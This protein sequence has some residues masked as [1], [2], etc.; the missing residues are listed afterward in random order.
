MSRFC[1]SGLNA[2]AVAAHMVENEG[3]DAVIGGGLE[4]ITMLQN[5]FN[6]TNLF[7]PW[8]MEHYKQIYM[9]MG[10]TA[11]VVAERYKVSR[12]AQDEYA[13]ASQQRTAAFQQSGKDK[14]EIVPMTVTMAV[15]D[16]ATGQTTQKQVTVDRD[17]CNRPDTTLEGLQKLPPAF[18]EG[19]HRDGGQLVAVLRRRGGGAH[20]VGR[21]GRVAGRASRSASS[22]AASSPAARPTRWASARSSRCRSCSSAPASPST[23]STSS[24]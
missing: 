2:V 8:L 21:E 3:A 10:L 12:E 20:H 18:K 6:K 11:E 9:P 16:K 22:A 13:L 23:T 15:T 7:N 17:E 14:D 19:R 5:D 4:S 24:S 1:S